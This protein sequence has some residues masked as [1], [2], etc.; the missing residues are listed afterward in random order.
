MNYW[1]ALGLKSGEVHKL[2]RAKAHGYAQNYAYGGDQL[3][4]T[5]DILELA[6]NE[7]RDAMAKRDDMLTPQKRYHG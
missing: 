4:M 7:A 5:I 2:A 3:K 1:K 6:T